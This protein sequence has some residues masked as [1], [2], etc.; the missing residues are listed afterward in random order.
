MELG[1]K[2][3]HLRKE[4]RMTQEELGDLIGVTKASVQ[5]YENGSIVNLKIETI[6]KLS[7]IFN[8]T[9]AYLMGWDKFDEE[10]SVQDIQDEVKFIKKIQDQFGYVGTEL[11]NVVMDLN[12]EGFRKVLFYAEDIQDRYKKSR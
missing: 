4:A 7:N 3:K 11:Y 9:P 5:K 10:L 8:V 6:N 1:E 2:I 12:E